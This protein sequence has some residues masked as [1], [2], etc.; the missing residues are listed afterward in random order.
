M[1]PATCVQT[2][3]AANDLAG[4]PLRRQCRHRRRQRLHRRAARRAPAPPP[5]GQAHPHELRDARRRAGAAAPAAG[6][7]RPRRSAPGTSLSGVDV[8]FVCTPHGAGG[9]G[10]QAPARRRRPGRSTCSADFR[11]DADAYAEWYGEH[12]HPG[13]A[14]RPSTG[15]PSC[16]ASEV[17]G[18]DARRQPRL[19]P[20]G[21]A[22]GAGAAQAARPARRRH[23]RQVGRE[24]RRQV[25]ER[26]HPLLQR[27][28]RPR[29]LRRGHAPPLPGDRRR[30]GGDAP[31]SA[32]SARP[33]GP[34]PLRRSPSSR[35][36]CRCSAASARRST[37]APARCRCPGRRARG[38]VRASS[39]PARRFVE[40]C[41]APPQLK[42]VAGTNYCRIFADRRRA[43]RAHHR[44][45]RHRQP[46]EGRRRGRRVQ[47]MN[48]M[49]GLPEHE[50]LVVDAAAEPLRRRCPRCGRAVERRRHL[51]AGLRAPPASP[52][53]VKKRGKLDLGILLSRTSARLG[54]HV[55][56]QRRR[57]RARAPHARDQR[58]RPPARRGRQ[59]RQRQRLHRQAGTRRRRPHAA[60]HRRPAAVCLWNRSRWLDRH[61]RRAA[62]DGA[63]R[64]RHRGRRREPAGA[65]RRATSPGPSA[66][67]TST[68]STA[69]SSWRSPEGAV[70]LGFAAKGCGMISPN[71]ATMLCF[72]T[73]D[74][75]VDAPTTGRS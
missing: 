24:R 1:T 48:V 66:R 13:A 25:A 45:Q 42:D 17:A 47:N 75:V 67:P 64:A 63:H 59:R 70:R 2:T 36:W 55:H 60:A 49:L 35:T 16:T 28:L 26:P 38:A 73:C 12:P 29:R 41:D 4:R 62:A 56:E 69:P 21:G 18:A 74:A 72:V 27:R 30:P 71:M 57:R 19:L 61:H 58:L 40:V 5:L 20:H 34:A 31:A 33:G 43:R 52:R 22:A 7:H 50:G 37:C 8:A 23:R 14:A 44:H 15:S 54:G 68:P 9:A 65:R 51:P 11:L 53:G 39:T 46:D 10:R 3:T 32:P 6:A